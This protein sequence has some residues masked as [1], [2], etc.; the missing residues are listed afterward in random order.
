MTSTDNQAE[1]VP[2]RRKAAKVYRRTCPECGQ[3]FETTGKDRDFCT[4][5]HKAAF[6]NRSSAIG[7]KAIPLAMA[8]RAARNAKGNSPRALAL[9]ASGTRAFNELCRILDAAIAEDREQA[10]MPKLEYIRRRAA[11]QGLL[12]GVESEAFH[13]AKQAAATQESK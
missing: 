6:H 11:S 12:N 10:R 5:A 2:T 7:R 3:L 13:A 9:K 4:D 1:T 8:W